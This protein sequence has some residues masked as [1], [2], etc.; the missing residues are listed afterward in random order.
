MLQNRIVYLNGDFLPWEQATVHMLSHSFSRGSAIFEVLS[1]HETD[2]GPAIFRLDRHI[3][4]L[5][6]SAEFL[7]MDLPLSREELTEIV[8]KTVRQNGLREGE[9]KIMGYWPQITFGLLPPRKGIDIAVFAVSREEYLNGPE[10]PARHGVSLCISRWSKLDPRTVPVEAK[11]AANYLNGMM[12]AGDARSRG[13]DMGVMLDTQGFVAEGATDSIFLV[14]DGRLMTPSEGTI[15]KS[16]TRM[17]IIQAAKILDIECLEARLSPDRLLK[18]DEVFLSCTP[19]KIMPA[20]QLEERRFS[21][22]PGP[23]TL[24][25]SKLL[26]DIVAG[27]D[28]RFRS[29][30]FPIREA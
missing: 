30:L 6:K 5:F 23:L 12:A 20:R 16:I 9:I 1:F 21:P 7:D 10:I 13:F 29:W 8:S 22:V 4:R 25:V 26:G 17:S 3:D 27:R 18:A 14:K 24:A 28:K 19:V 2:A 15:L 11:A